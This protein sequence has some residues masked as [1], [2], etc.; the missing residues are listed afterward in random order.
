MTTWKYNDYQQWIKDGC[1]VNDTV[2][3]LDLF[4]NDLII[5][6]DN[7]CNL[8]NLLKFDCSCNQLTK[9]P[10]T[11]GN[12]INLQE[13]HCS[14]NR[15]TKL[16]KSLCYLINLQV[17]DCSINN[18]TELPIFIIKFKYLQM[19]LYD[20]GIR[21]PIYLER[22]IN[23]IN[24]GINDGI[25][26]DVHNNTI[27]ASL[28]DSINILL[29]ETITKDINII[30]DNILDNK[31]KSIIYNYVDDKTIGEL[32]VNFEELLVYILEKIEN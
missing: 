28:L 22:F 30:E 14:N 12:L 10:K 4:N 21:L 32:L 8:I 13:L 27:Q 31:T 24:Y 29:L 18:L 26:N 1:K 9:L 17:L 20:I 23:K 25:N 11:L 6:S 3:T 5:L 2:T 19:F 16:P 15:L 7:I